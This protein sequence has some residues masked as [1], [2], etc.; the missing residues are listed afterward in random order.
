MAFMNVPL[1]EHLYL[2][3]NLIPSI[4]TERL[5]QV[6][7]NLEILDLSENMLTKVMKLD[8]ACNWKIDFN[9]WLEYLKLDM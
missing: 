9:E 6:F 4:E 5:F 7:K 2:K 1:L 8:I 3:N